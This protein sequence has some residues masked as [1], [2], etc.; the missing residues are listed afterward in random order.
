MNDIIFLNNQ[1]ERLNKINL[2]AICDENWPYHFD[3][4]ERIERLKVWRRE[5]TIQRSNK[6]FSNM[7]KAFH[8][9]KPAMSNAAIALN[10]IKEPLIQMKKSMTI[11]EPQQPIEKTPKLKE[12]N[13]CGTDET[14]VE[15]LECERCGDYY[16]NDAICGSSFNQHTQIDYNCCE[17]CSNRNYS[18]DDD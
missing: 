3:L 12:C 11:G 17:P 18:Y 6:C 14:E 5:L 9:L 16:C 8:N 1:I 7:T 4:C 15:I 2:D 13:Q 10:K